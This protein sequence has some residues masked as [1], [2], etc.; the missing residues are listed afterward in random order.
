MNVGGPFHSRYMAPAAT[1]FAAVLADARFVDAQ[2]PVVLNTTTTP[3]SKAVALREELSRQITG[4]VRWEESVRTLESI[5]CDTF[6]E[7]GPGA[8]LSGLV[9]R[10]LS[11]ATVVS[12]GAPEGL[13][14]AAELFQCDGA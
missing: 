11:T 6:I 4:S 7:L 10:T 3:E 13:R 14:K 9:R 1:E 2:I 8:V 5:G 12:A